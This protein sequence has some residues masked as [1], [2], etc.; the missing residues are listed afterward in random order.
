MGMSR[1]ECN[2][3]RDALKKAAEELNEPLDNDIRLATIDRLRGRLLGSATNSDISLDDAFILRL[4]DF[5][6]SIVCLPVSR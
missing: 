1:Y 2:L 3:S 6:I 5:L 4:A